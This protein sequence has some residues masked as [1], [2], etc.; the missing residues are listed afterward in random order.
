MTCRSCNLPAVGNGMQKLQSAVDQLENMAIVRHEEDKMIALTKTA[1][2]KAV[3]TAKTRQ[4]PEFEN[5]P[6][7][8]HMR[9]ATFAKED[10]VRQLAETLASL[11]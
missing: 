2:L 6:L 1:L 11:N 4:M 7:R 10:V 8:D 9:S 5:L 3:Q